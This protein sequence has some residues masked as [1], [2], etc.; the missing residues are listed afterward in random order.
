MLIEFRVSNH[1]SIRDEQVLTMTAAG[2]RGDDHDN[3]PR[4]VGLSDKILPVAAI[5]G[6]NA[7]GKSNVLSALTFLREAVVFSQRMWPPGEGIPREPFAWHQKPSDPSIY[8]VTFLHNQVKYEFGFAA[9]DEAIVEEWLYA[10]PHGKKQTWYE[11]DLHV[12]KFGPN[13]QGANILIEEATRPD[14]LFL[15]T[16]VQLK[17]LQLRNVYD[18]FWRMDSMVNQSTRHVRGRVTNREIHLA[19]LIQNKPQMRQFDIFGGDNHQFFDRLQALMQNADVGI[20]DFRVATDAGE[21]RSSSRTPRIQLRHQSPIKDAWLPLEEESR[22]TRTLLNLAV[23]ILDAIDHGSVLLVDELEASL[24]P[25][26]AESIVRQFNDPV[27]N[28]NNAQIIFTT[29]DT[30]LLGTTLGD[31]VVRRDEVWLTEKNDEGCTVLYPLTDFKPR[32]SE[33]L[34]RGYLQGRYNAV[35]FLGGF[36]IAPEVQRHE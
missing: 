36:S 16:A 7:S 27:T 32:V 28:P 13:L 34:E 30:N 15:S 6:A 21:D 18:W 11:R 23:P 20:V 9:S 29:H 26:I 35:P 19:N 12:F 14:G 4:D 2:G 8:E 31:P 1:R 24:H 22:G 33:N 5:Y 10:W 17:H 25:K 3:R